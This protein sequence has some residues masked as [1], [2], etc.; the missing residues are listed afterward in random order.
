MPFFGSLGS[1]GLSKLAVFVPPVVNPLI[2]TG[3][4]GDGFVVKYNSTGTPLWSRRIGGTLLDVAQSV[5]TD[6]TGNV[7]VAGWY[8][9]SPLNIYAADGTTVSFTLTNSGSTDAFIVKYDSSGT[10]V[11]VRKL[12]A[13][14]DD[15]VLSVITD[16]S[17]NVIVAGWF[18][19][20]TLNIYAANGTTVSFT[21]TNS[22]FGGIPDGF[23]VKYDSSGTPLWV[24]KIGG[25]G[26]EQPNSVSV[27]S[28]GNVIVVGYFGSDPL[29]IYAANGTTVSF[30]LTNSGNGEAFVVKYDPNGTALWASKI[31]GST[32]SDTALSVSIDSSGN[33]IFVGR[34]N[35]TSINTGP[36]TFTN[37]GS[38]DA[39]VVKYDP[40]G[41]ALWARRIGGTLSDIGNSV[42]TDSSENVIV[43]GQYNSN[44]LNIY[45][46]DGTTVSF[47]LTNSGS[48]DAFI[49]KYDSSGT[50][51]W[52][53]KLGGTANNDIAWSV[54]V[55]SSGNI[56]VAG[57]YTSS[58]FNIYGANGSTV[59]FTLTNSGVYDGFVVKYDSSGTPL[60]VRK[61][62]GTANNDVAW[63][64]S[65]DSS[66]NIVVAGQY[67]STS[68]SFS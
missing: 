55:D 41:T 29:N 44:P 65:T 5:S 45:A 16:L 12:A 61:I 8:S 42:S 66:G 47:T 49:V 68:L 37:S 43:A 64:V 10:P 11:W 14:V 60:W 2:F 3:T 34:Y 36:I 32:G 23:V 18:S 13:N 58:P 46:A 25:T 20:N 27:D 38:D 57:Q 51:V 33:I 56:V 4:G 31:G 19:S 52:V 9:S 6:S 1:F 63:S 35:S 50:P 67:N 15:R 48:T 59:S 21:L 26:G 54:S 53:R 40:N 28:S 22:A 24:R 7:I 62:G 30:T 17:G 39:L